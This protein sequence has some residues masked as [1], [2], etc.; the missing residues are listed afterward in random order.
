MAKHL[1]QPKLK[2]ELGLLDGTMLGSR[3]YDW[4]GDIYSK[5]RYYALGRFGRL[6]YCRL[7]HHRFYDINRGRKLWR[8]Q[9]HVPESWWSVRLF[10]GSL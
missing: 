10:K 6:A 8:T 4:L 5:R 9:R 3:L 2:H 7:A 1:V